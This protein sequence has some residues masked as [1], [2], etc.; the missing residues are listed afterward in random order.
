[1]AQAPPYPLSLIACSRHSILVV[2]LPSQVVPMQGCSSQCAL[3]GP[4]PCR[5]FSWPYIYRGDPASLPVGNYVLLPPLS[6]STAP[7]FT[8]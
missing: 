7:T 4:F 8:Y 2:L 5:N 6:F 1:M 3:S